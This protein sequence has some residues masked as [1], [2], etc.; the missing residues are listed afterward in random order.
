[1]GVG[2]GGC[3]HTCVSLQASHHPLL[4]W[5]LLWLNA[6][7]DLP[8]QN[9]INKHLHFLLRNASAILFFCIEMS[10]PCGTYAGCD[11][12]QESNFL[13]SKQSWP[14]FNSHIFPKPPR[15]CTASP[16]YF[17]YDLMWDLGTEWSQRNSRQP[18]PG[19]SHMVLIASRLGYT[20]AN[21]IMLQ[22]QLS[23]VGVV[24]L[25]LG[26]KGKFFRCSLWLGLI[27][28]HHLQIQA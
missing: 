22:R 6:Y 27:N 5:F 8:T 12:S 3:V 17:S 26:L 28:C 23:F 11:V 24:C 16:V 14:S 19:D 25:F 13:I 18:L 9:H 4:S 7:D 15:A 10:N 20:E 21:S 1:M 2:Q